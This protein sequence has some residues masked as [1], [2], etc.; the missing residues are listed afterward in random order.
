MGP[1]KMEPEQ[2]DE[3]DRATYLEEISVDQPA[4]ISTFGSVSLVSIFAWSWLICTVLEP[5]TT[6]RARRRVRID[7]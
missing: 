3:A 6:H 5:N 1:S 2:E 7:G 4:P